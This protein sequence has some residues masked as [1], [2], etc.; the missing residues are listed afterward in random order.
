MPYS[1]QPTAWDQAPL[2]AALHN[3]SL[4]G[5]GSG[6]GPDWFLDTGATSHMANHPG[7]VSN[8]TPYTNSS[9]VVV[10]DGSSLPITHV[11]FSALSM[12]VF[13]LCYFMRT[14]LLVFGLKP[15]TPPPIFL[16][17]VLANLAN[18]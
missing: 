9:R 16:I 13:V 2:H 11:A 15:S 7:I 17:F 1:P 3:L 4:Q 14:F 6:A 12:T 8:L 10:G 18:T 5:N